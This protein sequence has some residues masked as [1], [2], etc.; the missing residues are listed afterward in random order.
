MKTSLPINRPQTGIWN[1][2]GIYAWISNDISVHS[3]VSNEHKIF[4]EGQIMMTAFMRS[5][6]LIRIQRTQ[7]F[8]QKFMSNKI[9]I[10]IS[11]TLY[12]SILNSNL[13]LSKIALTEWKMKMKKISEVLQLNLWFAKSVS[14]KS[15]H[16]LWCNVVDYYVW[17]NLIVYA[18]ISSIF[19]EISGKL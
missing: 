13:K 6:Y 17:I 15:N 7:H 19:K 16:Y 10:S 2:S 18:E 11:L 12:Q 9:V 14:K 3:I 4:Y 1:V 8:L 5:Y